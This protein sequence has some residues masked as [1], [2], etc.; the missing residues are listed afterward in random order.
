MRTWV[1]LLAGG[2]LLVVALVLLFSRAWIPRFSDIWAD[3]QSGSDLVVTL[4]FDRGAVS[5][6]YRVPARQHGILEMGFASTPERIIVTSADGTPVGDVPVS[7]EKVGVVIGGDGSVTIRAGEG[8]P[9]R[10]AVDFSWVWP[11]DE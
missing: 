1:V 6:A 2:V 7:G 4:V 11:E 9:F 8:V 5:H 10:D 3:N